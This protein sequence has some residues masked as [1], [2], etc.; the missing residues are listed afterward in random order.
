MALETLLAG[1]PDSFRMELASGLLRA[2]GRVCNVITIPDSR[3][4]DGSSGGSNMGRGIQ[5]T[6][7]IPCVGRFTSGGISHPA[8]SGSVDQSTG[9]CNIQDG[10]PG[11]A[12]EDGVTAD[13]CMF[14]GWADAKFTGNVATNGYGQSC[15]YAISLADLANYAMGNPFASKSPTAR[16][17]FHAAAT[18]LSGLNI[19]GGRGVAPNNAPAPTINNTAAIDMTASPGTIQTAEIGCGSSADGDG[20]TPPYVQLSPG[21]NE[22]NKVLRCAGAFFY[23]PTATSGFTLATMGSSQY[24]TD[25]HLRVLGSAGAGGAARCTSANAR[26]TIAAL[27]TSGA[28]LVVIHEY[29]NT[30]VGGTSEAAEFALS[31]FTRYQGHVEANIDAW[32]AHATAILGRR[33]DC[34][35]LR[36]P[37]PRSGE[38][39]SL[40]SAMKSAAH[41]A[42]CKKRTNCCMDAYSAFQP[43]DNLAGVRTYQGVETSDG[44]HPT[45]PILVGGFQGNGDSTWM[46]AAWQA[47]AQ[48]YADNAGFSLSRNDR[49]SR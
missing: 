49:I 36:T 45:G 46:S 29:A 14:T 35:W 23:L 34:H 32:D 24:T 19:Q 18:G 31:T 28:S 7:R 22:T 25:D 10:L 5:R 13:W 39:G 44:I 37:F 33:V 6:F 47:V 2:S 30:E 40:Y 8:W 20:L 48:S 16:L 43:A 9:S 26:A 38:I 15:I 21:G 12:W 42:I 3:T 27:L 4:M 1:T 17:I 41:H 11:T